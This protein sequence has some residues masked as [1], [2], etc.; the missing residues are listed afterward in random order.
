MTNPAS[1]KLI[2]TEYI[3]HWTDAGGHVISQVALERTT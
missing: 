1:G 2:D 3:M